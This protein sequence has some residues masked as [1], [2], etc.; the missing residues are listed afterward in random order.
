MSNILKIN[1]KNKNFIILLLNI[2]VKDNLNGEF[3]FFGN[4][5]SLLFHEN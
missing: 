3:I 2:F 5:L 4:K 1:I